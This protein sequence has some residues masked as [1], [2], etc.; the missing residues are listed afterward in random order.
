M[1]LVAALMAGDARKAQLGI[2]GDEVR[3]ARGLV[4]GHHHGARSHAIDR[5]N[6]AEAE[7]VVDEAALVLLE[8]PLIRPDLRHGQKIRAA[9]H[10]HRLVMLQYLRQELAEPDQWPEQQDHEAQRAHGEGHEL[11][12][13][14]GSQGL[15]DEFGEDQDCQ[16]H[17]D[18]NQQPRNQRVGVGPDLGRLIANADGTYGMGD[19]VQSQDRRQWSVDVLLER[20]QMAT[21]GDGPP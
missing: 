14:G 9:E 20:L 21:E 16:G 3:Q 18:R 8:H 5:A 10:G 13:V 7:Q 15:G 1:I 19:G 2:G 12:P 4:C 6:A 11:L 17:G